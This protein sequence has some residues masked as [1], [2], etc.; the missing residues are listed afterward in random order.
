MKVRQKNNGKWFCDYRLNGVRHRPVFETKQAANDFRNK[1]LYGSHS[2]GVPIAE[3]CKK[4]YDLVS[5][6]KDCVLDEKLWLARFIDYLCGQERLVYLDD[7]ELIHLQGLQKKLNSIVANSSVNRHFKT[8]KHFFKTCIKWGYLKHS[9]AAYLDSLSEEYGK[10]IELTDEQVQAFIDSSPSE[11]VKDFVYFFART[12]IRHIG[13]SR[14][15]WIDVDFEKGHITT[16]S[17]KGR[18]KFVKSKIPMPLDV[19]KFLM[20]LRKKHQGKELG[21]DNDPVFLNNQNRRVRPNTIQQ[22]MSIAKKKLG[23]DK[24]E[25]LVFYCCRKTLVTKIGNQSGLEIASKVAGHTN[26]GTTQKYYFRVYDNRLNDAV[27]NV[28][29][30]VNR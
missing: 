19:S 27:N 23:F 4:Y 1:I 9:P 8:Y 14:L 20:D 11:W 6:T 26:T 18:G 17:K 7:I 29:T 10:R 28:D 12:G 15:N 24:I 13:I 3:T 22:Y 25:N 21:Q 16:M 5:T 2:D 30:A